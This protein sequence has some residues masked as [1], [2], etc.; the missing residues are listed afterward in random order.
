MKKRQIVKKIMVASLAA[1]MT[2]SAMSMSA[3]AEENSSNTGKSYNGYYKGKSSAGSYTVYSPSMKNGIT[4]IMNNDGI[5]TIL[6]GREPIFYDDDLMVSLKSFAVFSEY[7]I[8]DTK[9]GLFTLSKKDTEIKVSNDLTSAIINGNTVKLL[10]PAVSMD[11]DIFVSWRDLG[12]LFN[13]NVSWDDS[14]GIL[15]FTSANKT[16]KLDETDLS[17]YESIG[18]REDK[19]K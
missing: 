1:I 19:M 11:D 13:Y 5:D 9:D 16:S 8:N 2:A 7:K 18:N 15:L 4:M 17:V 14:S 3:F 6:V 12:I 10:R